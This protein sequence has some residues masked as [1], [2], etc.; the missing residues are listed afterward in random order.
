MIDLMPVKPQTQPHGHHHPALPLYLLCG[1][2]F[3]YESWHNREDI[4]EQSSL[5]QSLLLLFYVC[6]PL[7][8]VMLGNRFPRMV[9]Y[10]MPCPVASLSTAVYTLSPATCPPW[11]CGQWATPGRPVFPGPWHEGFKI[12][13]ANRIVM[14]LLFEEDFSMENGRC[15]WRSA[16]AAFICWAKGSPRPAWGGFHQ[17]LGRILIGLPGVVVV[18][19]ESLFLSGMAEATDTWFSLIVLSLR[20]KNPAIKLPIM[21]RK[22][23][24][25]TE[26]AQD[27]WCFVLDYY[28]LPNEEPSPDTTPPVTKTNFAIPLPPPLKQSKSYAQLFHC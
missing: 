27:F 22:K 19:G 9:T 8:S 17:T 12:P 5:V 16:P 18:K 20:E 1:G 11:C 28:G 25:I 26:A 21:R 7:V 4:L 13:R 23:S 2:L 10:I 6:Y 3:L 14:D 24:L 15:P